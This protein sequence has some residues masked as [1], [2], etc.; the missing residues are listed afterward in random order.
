MERRG[1]RI[2][3][4]AEHRRDQEEISPHGLAVAK[5]RIESRLD[6]LLTWHRSDEANERLAKHLDAHRDQ[7]FTF[8]K[9]PE[10][11]ATNW[12]AEQAIRPAVI[13]RKL[14]GGNRT[15]RGAQA[16]AILMSVFR[17]C[18]QRDLDSIKLL[19][20]LQRTTDPR[21]FASMALGP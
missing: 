19:V 5:G 13:N 1:L 15:E 11:E 2:Q 10:V 3:L 21:R 8:L 9:D 20:D 17:T 16:Q 4:E 12:P 6:R 18:W 7:L 14:S